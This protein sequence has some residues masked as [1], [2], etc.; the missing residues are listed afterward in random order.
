MAVASFES[1]VVGSVHQQTSPVTPPVGGYLSFATVYFYGYLVSVALEGVLRFLLSKMGAESLFYIRD[2]FAAAVF[3]GFIWIDLLSTGRVKK[4]ELFL[5]WFCAVYFFYSLLVG[6]G[7]FSVVFSIKMMIPVV[8]GISIGLRSDGRHLSYGRIYSLVFWLSVAGVFANRLYGTFPWQGYEY[9]S[10]FG[11]ISSS[12]LW[13]MEGGI[14][15]LAGFARSSVHAA[16]VIGCFGALA[17]A[18]SK[19]RIGFTVVAIAALGA[20]VLTTSKGM[21]AAFTLLVFFCASALYFR[22]ALV[23]KVLLAALLFV[24]IM[25]PVVSLVVDRQDLADAPRFLGSFVARM[26][27]TWPNAFDA[28]DTVWEVFFGSGFGGVGTPMLMGGNAS[29]FNPAD[30]FLMYTYGLF[31]LFGVLSVLSVFIKVLLFRGNDLVV[32]ILAVLCAFI[33]YGITTNHVETPIAMSIFGLVAG[34]VHSRKNL[35]SADGGVAVQATPR[36]R[37]KFL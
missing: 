32:P 11:V 4:L 3:F 2:A 27:H 20:L 35:M 15:R 33:G 19:T 18:Y 30:N 16:A 22:R 14:S 6:R 23:L 26:I 13:W 5:I 37:G 8:L 29:N 1:S 21:L 7:L 36:D 25:L 10:A 17:L 34:Y 9:E 28:S 12:R 31:G 24:A